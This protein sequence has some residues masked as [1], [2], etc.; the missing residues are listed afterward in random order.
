MIEEFIYLYAY[1]LSAYKH[2]YNELVCVFIVVM[3]LTNY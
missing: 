2:G 1:L 3:C